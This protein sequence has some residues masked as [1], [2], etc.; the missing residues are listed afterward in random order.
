M[1]E[2]NNAPA[3]NKS[4]FSND[5]NYRDLL[6]SQPDLVC[7]WLPDGTLTFANKAYCDY[8]GKDLDDLVGN[9]CLDYIHPDDNEK[10]IQHI[11]RFDENHTQA[12]IELKIIDPWGKIRYHQWN[13]RYF[14]NSINKRWEFIS[15]GRDVTEFKEAEI[16]LIK[17]V[18]FERLI[19]KHTIDFINLSPADIDRHITT[20]LSDIGEYAGVDRSYVFQFDGNLEYLSNTHEWCRE[21]IKP[22]IESLQHVPLEEINWWAEK[23]KNFETLLFSDIN[24]LPKKA[25]RFRESLQAQDILSVAGV[26]M[27]NA[28]EI[29]GFVGFDAVREKKYWSETISRSSI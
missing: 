27:V 11:A 19:T 23:I 14:F 4:R 6:D 13:D 1:T 25:E 8:F 29:L 17:R 15:T 3:K 22:Q 28:G 16:E 12:I 5:L 18:Q 7:R 2:K 9:T 21:G 10:L 20:L 24:A 26:P